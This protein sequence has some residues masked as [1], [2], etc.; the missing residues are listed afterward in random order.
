M[1]ISREELILGLRARN[2]GATIHY[3][4]LHTMPLYAGSAK[5]E[6]LPASEDIARRCLTLPISASMTVKDADDV[7]ASIEAVFR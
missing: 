7:I 4:P 5:A 6:H 2:I 3:H 1:A